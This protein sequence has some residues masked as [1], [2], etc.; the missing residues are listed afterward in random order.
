MLCK[1]N[2]NW[3]L[4]DTYKSG[5]MVLVYDSV[6]SSLDQSTARLIQKIFCC[7]PINIKVEP[8]QQQHGSNDCGMYAIHYCI[9][10]WT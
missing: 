4:T 10:F 2:T 5:K 6:Y 1:Y 9:C 3:I 8:T 7:T